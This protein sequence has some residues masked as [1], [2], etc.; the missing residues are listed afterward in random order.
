M[1]L[2]IKNSFTAKWAKY[3]KRSELP[4]ACFYSDDL[5]GADFIDVKELWK[6]SLG[7]G[8]KNNHSIYN[9]YYT[10]LARRNDAT[11]IINDGVLADICNEFKISICY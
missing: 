6:E 4:I 7:E 2:T 9:M 8:I 10:I 1:D 11:L 3:F 5:C